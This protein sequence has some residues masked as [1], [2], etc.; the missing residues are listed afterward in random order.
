M[1]LGVATWAATNVDYYQTFA[2]RPDMY[3]RFYK[4]SMATAWDATTV[5]ISGWNFI[6]DQTVTWNNNPCPAGWRL[7]TKEEFN[8]LHNAGSTWVEANERGNAVAGRFYG[9]DHATC[10]LPDNLSGC[11]F[12]PAAGFRRYSD[13]TLVFQGRVGYYWS[14]T[15]YSSTNGYSLL[16]S[17]ASSNPIDFISKAFGFSIRCVQ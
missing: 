12:L 17:S 11:I 4:W 14:N 8:A 6:A 16:F 3:T 10:S 9:P 2:T 7:P 1:T 5:N 15:E 13:G